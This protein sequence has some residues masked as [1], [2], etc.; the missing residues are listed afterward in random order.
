MALDPSKKSSSKDDKNLKDAPMP[1]LPFAGQI[2]HKGD[3]VSSKDVD[4]IAHKEGNL[5]VQEASILLKDLEEKGKK[6]KAKLDELYRLRG[7]S[8]EF[9]ERYVSNPS[10]FTP[11]QWKVL[12]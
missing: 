9:I 3:E 5:T 7:E 8:P 6:I 2:I 10:N 4:R 1:P 11:E 12:S